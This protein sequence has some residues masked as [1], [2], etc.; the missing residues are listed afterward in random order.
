MLRAV[1]RLRRPVLRSLLRLLP[2]EGLHRSPDGSDP[3]PSRRQGLLLRSQ[4]RLR[5]RLLRAQLRLR[6]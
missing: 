4:L 5:R 3:R 2:Q 6:G 1:L